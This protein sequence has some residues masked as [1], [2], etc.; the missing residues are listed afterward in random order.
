MSSGIE[1]VDVIEAWLY[2]TL[3]SDA[4]L[5]AL[6]GDRVVGTLAPGDV[7]TPYV[8]FFLSSASDVSAVPTIRIQ[9]DAIYT[10]KAVGDGAAWGQVRDIAARVDELLHGVNT[11]TSNGQVSCVRQSIVQYAE[12]NQGTQYRHLGGLFRVRANFL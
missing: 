11:T 5:T 4:A 7:P 6:V 9:V 2:D 8:V 12:V 10:V 1:T 3:S